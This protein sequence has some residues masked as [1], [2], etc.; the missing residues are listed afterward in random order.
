MRR[1]GTAAAAGKRSATARRKEP[2]ARLPVSSPAAELRAKGHE[3]RY[4]PL[5]VTLVDSWDRVVVEVLR[6]KSRIDILI[7]NAGILARKTIVTYDEAA[8]RRVLDVNVTASF[9]GIQKVAARMCAR[10]SA[11]PQWKSSLAWNVTAMR[12]QR[13]GTRTSWRHCIPPEFELELLARPPKE[14]TPPLSYR[15]D[16]RRFRSRLT[17]KTSDRR[18][19][20]LQIQNQGN[21]SRNILMNRTV[22]C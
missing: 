18:F 7:N 4:L 12:R 8:W 17:L 10:R 19:S 13:A 20:K 3:A 21:N 6:W 14:P 1:L 5:D 15:I 9:L 11:N 22:F 16:I 2:K